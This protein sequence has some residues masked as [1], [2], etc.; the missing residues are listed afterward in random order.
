[1]TQPIITNIGFNTITLPDGD[2]NALDKLLAD[3]VANHAGSPPTE[4]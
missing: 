1:M 4:S 2:L 3:Y